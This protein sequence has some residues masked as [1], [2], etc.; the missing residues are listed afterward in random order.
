M[1]E[2]RNNETI[3][4]SNSESRLVEGYAVVFNSK[5]VDLGGFYEVIDENALEGVIERSDIVCLLD[6]DIKRGVLAR[7]RNNSEHNSLTLSVDKK[8]LKFSFEAPKTS[9]GDEILEGVRRGDISSC[10]FAFTV[11]EDEFTKQS[12]GSILRT[13]KKIDELFDISLV[14]RPAYENTEVD[15]RGLNEFL[16][17][18][19][20]NQMK[21]TKRNQE[22]LEDKKKKLDEQEIQEEQNEDVQNEDEVQEDEEQKSCDVKDDEK[23]MKSEDEED[24]DDIIEDEIPEEKM[25]DEDNL[26]DITEDEMEDEEK[27]LKKNKRNLNKKTKKEI[28]KNNLNKR[29][30]IMKKFRLIDTINDVINNRSFNETSKEVIERSKKI[31]SQNG[32][33]FG[34]SQIVLAN[35]ETREGEGQVT[36]NGILAQTAQYG[37]EAIPTDTFD[38]VG[39]L[40]D[41]M[42]LAEAGARFMDCKGNVEIPVYSGSV[43]DWADETGEAVDGRGSFTS[44][45]LV[46]KRLTAVLPVSRMFLAQTSDSAENILRED[47]INAVSEKLQQTIL[48][49]GAGSDVEPKGLFNGVTADTTD[50]TYADVLD[51]EE[52]LE[53]GNFNTDNAKWIVSPSA[54]ALLR[55]TKLDGGSGRFV[56]EDKEVL[57]NPALTTNSAVKKGVI[58]GDFSELIIANW[59]A[60]DVLVDPYTLSAKNQI[61]LVVHFYV[62]YALRRSDALV[63]KIL[64]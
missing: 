5:S 28:R 30:N 35:L 57:G 29:H 14:Y 48:G 46:P 24:L 7:Y 41:K 62:N 6:H 51:I 33:D 38:I 27:E 59:G 25:E 50:V 52:E 4:K 64:K 1:K 63:K 10:S 26:D 11:D 60:I 43:C 42:V 44:I 58:Y 12:D 20:K 39:A 45:K 40:R 2:V 9:L 13:I 19:N 15:T 37:K 36:P 34:A 47:L 22:D 61:R 8:G 49:A 23:E 17:N 55:N 32:I 56:Y 53:T 3:S 16:N 31:A 18:N 54:K 21:K